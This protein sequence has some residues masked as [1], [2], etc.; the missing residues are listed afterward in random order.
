MDTLIAGKHT[1]VLWEVHVPS[2]SK[3]LREIRRSEALADRM[4]EQLRQ[5]FTDPALTPE[6]ASRLLGSIKGQ[7]DRIEAVLVLMETEDVRADM[8]EAAEA[9]EDA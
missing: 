3:W 2:N 9:A 7:L 8:I 5:L 1:H 4:Q 6:Q